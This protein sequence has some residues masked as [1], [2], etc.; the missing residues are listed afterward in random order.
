[1]LELGSRS[2]TSS[3]SHLPLPARRQTGGRTSINLHSRVH[4]QF[5]CPAHRTR[6]SFMLSPL[7]HSVRKMRLCFAF[8]GLNNRGMD[9]YM[10]V[11]DTCLSAGNS[12]DVLCAF[13]FLAR[14]NCSR[15]TFIWS[16]CTSVPQSLSYCSVGDISAFNPIC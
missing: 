9:V 1:M 14:P 6:V 8:C 11:Y 5:D 4:K 10:S 13:P 15:G 7:K 3:N 2:T 12:R 16:K